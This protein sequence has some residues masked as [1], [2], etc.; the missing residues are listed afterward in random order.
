M[1]VAASG[2]VPQWLNF[3]D[4]IN[5]DG[6]RFVSVVVPQG[7]MGARSIGD[8]NSTIA[9]PANLA[10]IPMEIFEHET[11]LL[12]ETME[13]AED[14]AGAGKFR[15]GLGQKLVLR[16]PMASNRKPPAVT[17]RGGRLTFPGS[18]LLGGH[19]TP[20][21]A[22]HLND[23]SILVPG[24]KELK[25]GDRISFS[26][27]GGGGFLDPRERDPDKVCADVENGFVSRQAAKEVYGVVL[28]ESGELDAKATA[29]A[30]SHSAAPA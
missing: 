28:T 7:G 24:R 22:L 20:K 12:C 8:G 9:W 14:S 4:G 1:V 18:G 3:F 5:A 29:K 13:F 26:V 16:V 2:G 30:R 6:G 11:G 27:P 17:L 15:G 23:D 21:G 10:M 19:G 25:P